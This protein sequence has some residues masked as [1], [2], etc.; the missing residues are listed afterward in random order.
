MR[1]RTEQ[2]YTDD[3][4]IVLDLRV[5]LNK[6]EVLETEQAEEKYG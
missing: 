4:G 3:Q 5:G 1:Y 6:A 2:L